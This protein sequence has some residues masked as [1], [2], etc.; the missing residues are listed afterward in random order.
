[1][2]LHQEKALTLRRAK[3]SFLQSLFPTAHKSVPQLRFTNFKDN[4]NQRELGEIFTERS[5]R[6]SM[7]ELI[8]VTINSG[9]IK[10]SELIRKDNSSSNKSNYKIVKKNDIAYNSMR[11]WQGASGY[12]VYDG[13]LSPAYTVITPR[14]GIDAELFSFLFKRN[15]MIQIFQKNSQG[16]TSDTWNLKFPTL[17]KIKINVP[18][19][20]EQLTIKKF[21]KHVDIMITLQQTKIDKLQKIKKA[22]LQKMFI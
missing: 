10:S 6:S 21:L 1:M 16:L 14:E 3:K 2:A 5:D 18:D 19:N 11:M 22:Y 17:S 15:D 4:W 8:S 12:S 7:G 13:I 20:Q 9:V